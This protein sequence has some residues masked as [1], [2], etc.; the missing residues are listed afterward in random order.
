M[1]ANLSQI[2]NCKLTD[3]FQNHV[4]L[5]LLIISTRSKLSRNTR[6]KIFRHVCFGWAICCQSC[7]LSKECTIGMYFHTTKWR[8]LLLHW[9][10]QMGDLRITSSRPPRSRVTMWSMPGC[11]PGWHRVLRP[12][13][14]ICVSVISPSCCS[15][16]EQS[17]SQKR[18]LGACLGARLVPLD[19]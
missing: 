18:S 2:F 14:A 15:F 5:D 13:L 16:P 1:T 9:T 7:S 17:S 12:V 8:W 6:K 3:N 4:R 10:S 11:L 19:I